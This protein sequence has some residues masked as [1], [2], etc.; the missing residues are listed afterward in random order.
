MCKTVKTIIISNILYYIQLGHAACKCT[1]FSATPQL[2]H[3]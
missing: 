1:F 3:H 2:P